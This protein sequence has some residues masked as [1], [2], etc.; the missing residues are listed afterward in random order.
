MKHGKES[1][2]W[3]SERGHILE[4]TTGSSP[5][6]ICP[7][8]EVLNGTKFRNNRRISP[9]PA[10]VRTTWYDFSTTSPEE[11]DTFYNKEDEPQRSQL[12][13]SQLTPINTQQTLVAEHSVA[14]DVD[15]EEN[16]THLSEK[17]LDITKTEESNKTD[18]YQD[19]YNIQ[20][21]PEVDSSL[22]PSDALELVS[23]NMVRQKSKRKRVFQKFWCAAEEEDELQ[24][25]PRPDEYRLK[26]KRIQKRNKS[27][28]SIRRKLL[29]NTTN[30]DGAFAVSNDLAYTEELDERGGIRRKPKV[31]DF[32]DG[33]EHVK[34]ELFYAPKRP[35]P[36]LDLLMVLTSFFVASV[37]AY[38][39]AT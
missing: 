3:E 26:S 4:V 36:I 13:E 39:S 5:A 20:N 12:F 33:T 32:L 30:N 23:S 25:L 34:E 35:P 19:V 21:G 37:L 16:A 24:E 14:W 7:F 2:T 17:L 27:G 31:W 11:V 38:Y 10:V 6:S 1:V 8:N 28:A 9:R 15:R 18:P 22:V 29:G